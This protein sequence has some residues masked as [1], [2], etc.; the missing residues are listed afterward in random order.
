MKNKPF[1][2][3]LLFVVMLAFTRVS[4]AEK[5]SDVIVLKAKNFEHIEFRRIKPNVHTFHDQHLQIAVDNSASFL[6]KPFH[7]V[8][9]ISK[10][11][12]SWRSEGVPEIKNAQHEEQR[13]GDDAVFKLG[14]LLEGDDAL[15][16]PFLPSWMKRVEKLLN[17]PSEN[18]IYLVADAKHASGEQ[19][20]NPYN[21][22]ISMIA[23]MSED[24]GDGWRKAS[25]SF[26]VPVNVVALWLMSDG[27]NTDSSFTAHIKNVLIE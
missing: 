23:M 1:F 5:V 12:F 7:E 27:D 18:M 16:N 2:L 22:R 20:P 24:N 21:D 11:T 6:M 8:R 10:I 17:F 15:S 4:L 25:Y 13:P 26:D 14:L 3:F 19:W 9:K